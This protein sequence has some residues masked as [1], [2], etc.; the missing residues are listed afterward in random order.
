L[1]EEE[2]VLLKNLLESHGKAFS[3][4]PRVTNL[5]EHT[6]EMK[7]KAPFFQKPYQ[8]PSAYRVEVDRQIKEMVDWEIISPA[9]SSFIS[10][11][12]VVKKLMGI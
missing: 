4:K 5:Y 10:T 12:L 9:K 6:I 7:D 3:D 11:M 1:K 2:E 8:I